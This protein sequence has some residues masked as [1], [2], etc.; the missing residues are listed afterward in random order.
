MKEFFQ[1]LSVFVIAVVFIV[2]IMIRN[3]SINNNSAYNK[4]CEIVVKR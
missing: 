3:E 2:C 4:A 1:Y